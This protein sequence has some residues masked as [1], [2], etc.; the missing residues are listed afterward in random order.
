MSLP[1]GDLGMHTSCCSS[2]K[3]HVQVCAND[4]EKVLG[5]K[6]SARENGTEMVSS[7]V[8]YLQTWWPPSSLDYYVHIIIIY[9]I[10]KS[11][12]LTKLLGSHN[13]VLVDYFSQKILYLLICALLGKKTCYIIHLCVII[14]FVLSV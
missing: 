6:L 10:H 13:Y 3:L 8:L 5:T 9:T 1:W 4:N 2:A 7:F 14:N 11:I 12:I